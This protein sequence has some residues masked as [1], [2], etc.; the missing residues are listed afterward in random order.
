MKKIK[1]LLT[2]LL[3]LLS[4]GFSACDFVL[5]P[6]YFQNIITEPQQSAGQKEPK[7]YPALF[8]EISTQKIK[9]NVMIVNTMTRRVGFF[10]TET[11]TAQGSG[12][13]FAKEEVTNGYKYYVITNNHVVVKQSGYNQSFTVKDYQNNQYAAERLYADPEYDAAVISFQTNKELVVFELAENNPGINDLVISL[14]QPEGQSNTITF[15]D[16]IRYEKITLDDNKK[17]YSDV[18][19]SVIKHDAP[20]N[21]GSSGGALLN[22]D[23]QIVGLNYAAAKN[24]D[25]EFVYGYAVPVKKIQEFLGEMEEA[26]AQK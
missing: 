14:G 22:E 26:L 21:S 9:G 23:L 10:Q 13:I 2:V 25:G 5:S 11:A 8:N 7:D 18:T 6:D 4:F 12:F 15:G 16:V 24:S 3:I 19:F 17:E 20:I 1:A